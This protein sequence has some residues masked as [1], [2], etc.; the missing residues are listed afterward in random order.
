MQK[1][2]L[3]GDGGRAQYATVGI[4]MTGSATFSSIPLGHVERLIWDKSFKNDEKSRAL[5]DQ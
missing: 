4:H 3:F 2:V 1:V 5:R